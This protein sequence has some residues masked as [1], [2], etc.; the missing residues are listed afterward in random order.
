M[1][2]LRIDVADSARLRV[3]EP[4]IVEWIKVTDGAE[5]PICV[6]WGDYISASFETERAAL[7]FKIR[8]L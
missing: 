8:W 6:H 4:E 5:M 1:T 7:L 2:I 3:V